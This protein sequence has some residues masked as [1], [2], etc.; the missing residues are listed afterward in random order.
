MARLARLR[1]RFACALLLAADALWPG[2]AGADA[3][4]DQIRHQ[5]EAEP[6]LGTTAEAAADLERLRA[7]YAA[8]DHA[9]VWVDGGGLGAQAQALADAL[10]AASYDGLNPADY[11]IGIIRDLLAAAD[12]AA[13]AELDLRLSLGLMAFA[14]DLG[15]GRLEPSKVD[16]ELFVYPQDVDRA[17]VIRRAAKAPQIGVF[18]GQYRPKQVEYWR[19]KE[20]LANYRSIAAT[21]GWPS[22]P[23]GPT[24]EPGM[25]GPRVDA[26][27]DRLRR[28]GDLPFAEDAALHGGDRE[29]MDG[30]L[31]AAVRRFQ[32][33]HGLADDGKVG[34]RTLAALN[35]PVEQRIQQLVLNLERRRWMPDQFGERYVAVNLADFH[36]QVI[37]Q[38]QVVFDTPVVI[39]APLSR[40][41]VF[42]ADLTYLVLN[43]FWYVPPS[44]AT[45]ELLPKAQADPGYLASNGFELLS[46]W[47]DEATVLDPLSV[48][49]ASLS[50]DNFPYKLRQRPGPTNALGRLKFI[51]QNPFNVYL[52]DTPERGLFARAQRS[53]SHGC[54]RV[55]DPE[56][57]ADVLLRRQDD[58]SRAK[59][60][61][62]IA[63]GR[64]TFV[65]LAEPIPV[66]ITYLTAWVD[67]QRQVH[68]REDVYGRDAL[69]SRA[70]PP[71]LPIP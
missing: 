55:A 2:P 56:G 59:L 7:F 45:N 24:L 23:P 16:A 12:P 69:M 6:G 27:R 58:W 9:P 21:G 46:D 13:L 4:S 15:S 37:E 5:L 64:D 61:T 71:P 3:L 40:T 44:I 70:L 32:R 41:P 42:T 18:I 53:F 14:S 35:L 30:G 22:V 33:R 60:Q 36:L 52:H 39:G 62:A 29:V 25:V 31:V 54:I 8:R 34:R 26:L 50:P 43:P 51:M 38:G 65:G 19:L 68:F 1:P 17:E 57:L 47:H 10:A 49:W 67:E 66:H 48:D 20:A 63:S 11:S 28:T